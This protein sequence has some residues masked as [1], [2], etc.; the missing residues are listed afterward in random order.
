MLK[1]IVLYATYISIKPR[2]GELSHLIFEGRVGPSVVMGG[3]GVFNILSY[4]WIP[5]IIFNQLKK[6]RFL[7]IFRPGEG[8][9]KEERN[10]H[11]QE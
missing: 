7:F 10:S 3:V 4:I 11:V 1:L 5:L 8:R 6:K 2:G 9:E